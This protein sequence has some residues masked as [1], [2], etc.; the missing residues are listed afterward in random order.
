MPYVIVQ[1]VNSNEMAKGISQLMDKGWMPAGG[2][3]VSVA[4]AIP[5]V[6]KYTQAMYKTE[7]LAEDEFAG[8]TQTE[9]APSTPEEPKAEI[10][11]EE[12]EQ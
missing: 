9:R 10:E 5:L 1:A 7:A 12:E 2:V 11:I 4:S 3:A 6:E 8:F